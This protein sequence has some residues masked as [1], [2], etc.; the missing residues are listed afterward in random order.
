MLQVSDYEAV[1]PIRNWT[2]LKRRVGPY[3]RCFVFTH[4]SMPREP[5]VVLHTA[6][7][8]DI[9]KSIHVSYHGNSF[10]IMFILNKNKFFFAMNSDRLRQ[11]EQKL[12]QYKNVTFFFSFMV[13][14][15]TFSNVSVILW[16]SVLLVEETGIPRENHGLAASQ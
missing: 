9:T 16:R 1:H 2:D 7:T 13:F 10:I 12:C 8:S 6:L 14:N 5:V 11:F 3:R 4:S 15:A